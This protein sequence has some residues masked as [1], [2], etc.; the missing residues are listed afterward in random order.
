MKVGITADL[1]LKS[2]EET[3]ERY[4]ALG[5]IISDLRSKGINRLIVAGDLFDKER[6]HYNDFDTFCKQH[7]DIVFYITPGNHDVGIEQRFFSA[8]N[9]RLFT[10]PTP[11]EIDHI[12][13]LFLPYTSSGF[14]SMDELLASFFADKSL[15]DKW[16]LVGHG[17]YLEI[18]KSVDEYEGNYYMPLSNKLI[19][20]VKP[21]RAFLGHI[22]KPIDTGIV[23]YP[24]S[25]YPLNIN[26]TGKR[27]FLIYD[28]DIDS[29]ENGYPDADVI[30]MI[31]KLLIIP[32][33][34]EIDDTLKKIDATI[35]KWGF[36]DEE[37][38]K[39]KLRLILRGFTNDKGA[40]MDA[41][42]RQI[43]QRGLSF[44]DAEGPQSEALNIVIDKE[45]EAIMNRVLENMSRLPDFA[46]ADNDAIIEQTLL[47]IYKD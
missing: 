44:Y 14:G 42:T 17:D 8:S 36:T 15:P 3:P 24:G 45:R 41:V 10:T 34:N 39:V 9:I 33:E 19:R 27:R 30:Y 6:Y 37:L 13:F 29:I 46:Y 7:Q 40:L 38:S 5:D 12:V 47:L 2:K 4:D 20:E 25:P 28:T 23:S 22:H 31:E 26:E 43:R 35:A 32:T 16:I 18:N 21:L 11:V 1:H